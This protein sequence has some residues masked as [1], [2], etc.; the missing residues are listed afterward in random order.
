[1]I[2]LARLI[3][4]PIGGICICSCSVLLREGLC[5]SLI[6]AH[7]HIYRNYLVKSTVLIQEQFSLRRHLAMS[8]DFF[9]CNNWEVWG[10]T[11]IQRVEVRAAANILQ[12][13]EQY[14]PPQQ[15]IIQHEMSRAPRLRIPDLDSKLDNNF[16]VRSSGSI[17]N[18]SGHR[19]RA[20]CTL[21]RKKY[22]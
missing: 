22:F 9:S 5:K 20:Q 3:L 16:S 15:R 13:K 14:P 6:T 19:V 4:L 12:C 1:M 8:I 7:S 2:V 18:S 21:V 10:A 11:G 17:Y